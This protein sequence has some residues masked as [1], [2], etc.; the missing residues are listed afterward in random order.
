M[1]T[2]RNI[3]SEIL[4]SLQK[5]DVPY[6]IFPK[7][8]YNKESLYRG[9]DFNHPDS[10]LQTLDK[11]VYDR[12]KLAG[13]NR[14]DIPETLAHALHDFSIRVAKQEMLDKYNERS[15]VAIMGGHNMSRNDAEYLQIAELSKTLTE[16]NFLMVSGGGPG[17]ME[18]THLGAWFAGK[19][20]EDLKNAIDIMS[21]APRYNDKLWLSTA[22]QVFNKYPSTKH[23]SLS[24][25]T[26]FYGHEPPTPFATHIA[27]LFENS[28]REES[29]L[30][31]AKGGV[32]Y[33]PGSA[34]TMQEIFQDLA[35]NHYVT[36]GYVSPMIFMGKKYW[37]EDRPVY[38]LI[39]SLA[40]DHKLNP[41]IELS[42]FDDNQ[43]IIDL[44]VT[45]LEI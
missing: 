21:V 13:G 30:A 11:K 14:D 33:A 2:Q 17:A 29:L 9:F 39:R 43:S 8:L 12:F 15:V 37:T 34:G 40:D 27:K 5:L 4:E 16:K 38:T 44:L 22:F 7:E 18:A 24:I 6:S 20:S 42:I 23:Y 26:W 25:P 35:Q 28:L 10:Y 19:T 45:K 36:Y 32:I 3:D 31:I 41:D 1:N